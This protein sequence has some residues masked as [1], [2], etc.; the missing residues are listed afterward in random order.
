[1]NFFKIFIYILLL[2]STLM[3]ESSIDSITLAKVKKLIE[4][5]EELALAYKKYLLEKGTNPTSLSILITNA[6]LPKGFSNINPFGKEMKFDTTS[7]YKIQDSIPDN[8]ELKTNI[9]DYYY[10]NKYRIHT[11]APL[12]INNNKIEIILSS[13]EKFIYDNKENITT[14]K[15]TTAIASKYYLDENN[16]LHWYDSDGKYKFSYTKDLIVADDVI[17]FESDGKTVKKEF[18]NLMEEKGVRFAGQTILKKNNKKVDEYLAIADDKIIKA[19]DIGVKT[20]NIGLLQF[21]KYSGGMIVNGDIY[22]WGNNS[23]RIT[24]IN[25]DKYTYTNNGIKED[26]KNSVI[27]T[28]VRAKVKVYDIEIYEEIENNKANKDKCNKEGVSCKFST[29]N[30]N[31]P[32]GSGDKLCQD[33]GSKYYEQNYFSSP[34]RP[35]FVDLF[36]SVL[37]GTCGITT[38]GAL[39]CGGKTAKGEDE[40]IFSKTENVGNANEMLYRSTYFDGNDTAKKA[41]KIFALEQVWLILS[42]DG[43]I[44]RW[45][46]DEL[47]NGFSGKDESKLD[48]KENDPE[49]IS[50]NVSGVNFSDITYIFADKYRKIGA[51]TN[52]GD[53][54][55]WGKDVKDGCESKG[56]KWC[57]PTKI[58]I[59]NSNIIKDLKFESINGG[60]KSFIS[61]ATDG[62][63]YKI[64]QKDNNLQLTEIKSNNI[65]LPEK[66]LSL[67]LTAD[68]VAVYVN[69]E[70]KLISTHFNSNIFDNTF[71]TTINSMLW[72]SIKVLDESNAMCGLTVD[73]QMYCWGTQS[74]NDDKIKGVS[75]FMLPVFNTNLYDSTKDYLVARGKDKE[76]IDMTSETW[77]ENGKFNIKYPTYIGGFN[78][79]FIF[80]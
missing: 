31:P 3:A 78:Y 55:I 72:K 5:E 60:V 9:F 29:A 14:V 17:I 24:G 69:A 73:N 54:Y 46:K 51:L 61:L 10:S 68:G 33:L 65:S 23:N 67:D 36:A 56:T 45:G 4:K 74:Y 32:T 2:C 27:T 71:K 20:T 6:Y 16:I 1:M 34:L 62:K 41:K 53:I 7:P 42:E 21:G 19:N 22:T 13:K 49:K 11:K 76:F 44:Y 30:C 12:S 25:L 48:N 38:K 80:K 35:R 8:V 59:T 52:I 39:Y 77:K 63:Y 15:P 79:E 50:E 66:I 70:N 18:I 57:N 47:K 40:Y 26:N 64:E 28:L 37:H 75:T 58:D 43:S